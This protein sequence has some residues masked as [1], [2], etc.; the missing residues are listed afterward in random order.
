MGVKK[1]RSKSITVVSIGSLILIMMTTRIYSLQP[2]FYPLLIRKIIKLF[3]ILIL[4]SRILDLLYKLEFLLL[5]ENP[6]KL[7]CLIEMKKR[8]KVS[9]MIWKR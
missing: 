8:I 4:I 9:K 1:A 5:A 2:I 6:K 3:G 7:G